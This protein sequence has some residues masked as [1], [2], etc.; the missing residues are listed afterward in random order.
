MDLVS[1]HNSIFGYPQSDAVSILSFWT[2]EVLEG[3]RWVKKSNYPYTQIP[4]YVRQNTVLCLGPPE[5]GIP[6]YDYGSIGLHVKSYGLT[7]GEQVSVSIPSGKGKDWAGR[8]SVTDG[9][10]NIQGSVS[11]A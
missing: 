3:P 11:L 2:E 4:V 8:V 6:D 10:V 7:E 9:K 5:I 1:C